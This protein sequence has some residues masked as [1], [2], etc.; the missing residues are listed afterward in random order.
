MRPEF[1]TDDE[2]IA[3]I[4]LTRNIIDFNNRIGA[5]YRAD[6]YRP[7]L[8]DLEWEARRRADGALVAVSK[9]ATKNPTY[10]GWKSYGGR[11]RGGN[12]SLQITV[13]A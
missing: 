1:L 6:E 5:D 10:T 11:I 7:I 13:M 8:R 9:T 2:L 3:K 12:M 4:R